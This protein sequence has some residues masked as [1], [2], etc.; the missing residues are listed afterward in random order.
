MFS[1]SIMLQLCDLFENI[2]TTNI[3]DLNFQSI[4]TAEELAIFIRAI[5]SL[6]CLEE[7]TINYLVT[8]EHVEILSNNYSL[9][10]IGHSSR[11]TRW[12]DLKRIAS[13]NRF[14][15]NEKRFRTVKAIHTAQ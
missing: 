5:A 8:D 13:R 3:K 12:Y 9:T 14:L 10:H 7:V 11:D 2:R 15:K 6:E 1:R 4:F